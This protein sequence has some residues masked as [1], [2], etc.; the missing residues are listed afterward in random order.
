MSG[1]RLRTGA[2]PSAGTKPNR[3][4]AQIVVVKVSLDTPAN[5]DAS[6]SPTQPLTSYTRVVNPAN[7]GSDKMLV[8][9]PDANIDTTLAIA[10][11]V[12]GILPTENTVRESRP[13]PETF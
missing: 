12:A 2:S 9:P 13:N 3:E 8:V 6:R 1:D 5:S 11:S 7:G 10:G 4:Y